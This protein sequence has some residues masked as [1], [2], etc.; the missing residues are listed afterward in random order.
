MLSER[1]IYGLV[2]VII[3]I[4]LLQTICSMWSD[5]PTFDEVVNPSVGYAELFTGDYKL[6]DDHPPLYRLFTAFPFLVLQPYLPLQHDSWKKRQGGMAD[7]YDFAREFFY[8]GDV[9]A[10]RLLFWSRM[11]VVLLSLLLGLLVF[12]W[13]RELYG[14]WPGLFAF[15]LY[16]FEP[17]IITHSRLTT[18]DLVLT[19]FVFATL[20]QFWRY[21]QAPSLKFL[22]LTGVLF[23]FAL[24][25]KFSA[26]TILP[27]LVF[28]AFLHSCRAGE[29]NLDFASFWSG[30]KLLESVVASMKAG[31]I[32]SV[33]AMS[34]VLLFYRGQWAFF[35]RGIYNAVTHYEGGQSAFLMGSYST[36]GWWYYFPIAF[37]LKTPI[38][39]LIFLTMAFLFLSFRKNRAQHYFLLVPVGVLAGIAIV[40]HLNIG[41]RHILPV[42]PFLIVVASSVITVRFSHPRFFAGCIGGLALWYLWSALSIFPS[43]LAY[44]NEFVGQ[45][46][47]HEILVDSNLDWGQD[48]K[49]LKRFTDQKGIKQI[50]LSYFGT[51]APCYYGLHFAYLPAFPELHSRCELGLQES[52]P[53]FLAVS[54]TNLQAVYLPYKGSFEWLK[55]YRPIARIGYSIFVYDIRGDVAAR[56]NLGILYLKYRM[57]REALKEFQLAVELA[58]SESMVYSNLG[59][60]YSLLSMPSQ[61][62]AAY[63]RALELDSGNQVAKRRL[64]TLLAPKAR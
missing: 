59:F 30:R 46:R 41:I 18:N 9:D 40:G 17:N 63:R 50:Y 13:A 34:V 51:A 43:Y 60:T 12:Q 7:R 39:L 6:V 37:L 53:D 31:F 29:S 38:P 55:A 57:L 22:A 56:N 25:S 36:H 2:A 28:I 54:A 61:A 24:L 35:F 52:R 15:F 21:Y 5:S 27:I 58:P 48:L 33:V 10:D 23:G 3:A 64:E 44:F 26:I 4:F 47:R 62:E 20:Y 49:R 14:L 32:V 8:S 19:L 45:E 11:P 42:Y 1:M 16:S